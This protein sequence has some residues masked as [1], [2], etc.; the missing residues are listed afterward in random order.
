MA[1]AYCVIGEVVR[2]EDAYMVWHEKSGCQW[3]G[4]YILPGAETENSWN[5]Q[6]KYRKTLFGWPLFSPVGKWSGPLL[7]Q[8]SVERNEVLEEYG[9][10]LGLV[11]TKLWWEVT[12][13]KYI[14]ALILYSLPI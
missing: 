9:S 8:G 3:L 10:G 11:S 2:I 14:Y 4:V 6:Q 7:R 1:G 5:K 12:M 13:D